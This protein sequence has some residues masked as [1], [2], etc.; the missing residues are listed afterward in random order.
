MR[1]LCPGPPVMTGAQV[2]TW[3]L[4]GSSGELAGLELYLLAVV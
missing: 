2:L 4:L 1:A 3:G